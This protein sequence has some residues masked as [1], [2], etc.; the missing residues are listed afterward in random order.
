MKQEGLHS[1]VE[2]VNYEEPMAFQNQDSRFN[3]GKL[4][5]NIEASVDDE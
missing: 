5:L 1:I 3:M 4:F 2:E